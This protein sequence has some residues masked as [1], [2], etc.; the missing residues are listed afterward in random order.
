MKKIY[1][2]LVPHIVGNAEKYGYCYDS[3]W[4]TFETREA[5][6]RHG[7]EETGSDDFWVAEIEHPLGSP[8]NRKVVALYSGERKRTS[9][10]EVDAVN[11]EFGFSY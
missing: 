10:K 4:K 1:V 2:Y 5:A 3:D 7:E 6:Q 9:M 11:D 8:I